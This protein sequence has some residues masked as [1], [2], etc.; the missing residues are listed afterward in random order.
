MKTTEKIIAKNRP[1]NAMVFICL[2]GLSILLPTSANFSNPDEGWKSSRVEKNNAA[3]FK[4]KN[5]SP[6]GESQIWHQENQSPFGTEDPPMLRAKP[7][8]G[9]G[10]KEEPVPVNT[11]IWIIAGLA[12]IYGIICRKYRRR[13]R[14]KRYT[15]RSS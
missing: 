13:G 6:S 5:L 12:I 14:N 7:G 8:D 10:Q 3:I 1:R 15:I 4:E 2:C 11:E 9:T